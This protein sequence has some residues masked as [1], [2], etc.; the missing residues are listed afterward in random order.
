MASIGEIFA[1]ARRAKGVTLKDVEKSIKIRT[2]YVAAI[3]QNDFNV[4]PGQAYVVGFINT[5]ANYLGLDSKELVS[6]YYQEFL[7]DRQK[8]AYDLAKPEKDKHGSNSLRRS[9][10]IVIFL[11]LLIG[12]VLIINGKSR[13]SGQVNFKKTNNVKQNK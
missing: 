5:Y 8:P 4:I 2:K 7:P 13:S 12:A 11:I 1:E 3:E 10:A 9:L 6:R